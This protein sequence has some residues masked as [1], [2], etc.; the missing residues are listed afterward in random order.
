MTMGHMITKPMRFILDR[1]MRARFIT[2]EFVTGTTLRGIAVGLCIVGLCAGA[3]APAADLEAIYGED[4]RQDL[5][6]TSIN[7]DL[8]DLAGG[9]AVLVRRADILS[10][11]ETDISG[12]TSELRRLAGMSL[13]RRMG[14]CS[15]ERFFSEPSPGFCTAFLVSD[16]IVATAGHCVRSAVDCSHTAIV[17]DFMTPQTG[18]NP[19]HIRRSSVFICRS[20]VAR[21]QDAVTGVDY[22]LLRLERPA[23]NRPVLPLRRTGRLPDNADLAIIGHPG[24][25]PMKVATDGSV[26]DN[27]P[28]GFFVA[29]LDT[30]GGSSGTPVIDRRTGMVEG[31]VVRGERGY[32]PNGPCFVSRQCSLSACRGEDVTRITAFS[33]LLP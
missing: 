20:I 30:G 31:I 15:G 18:G 9:I 13:G 25:I 19:A 21:T 29:A 16:S 12:D 14:L 7:P 10:L 32:E 5:S 1:L 23:A 27:A 3:A 6:S 2:G 24:G 26:R 11:P 17:F 8:R 4:D 22:A 28:A 33:T